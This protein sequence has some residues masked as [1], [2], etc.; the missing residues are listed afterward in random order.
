MPVR[1]QVDPTALAA[2]N[3]GI[4][5]VASA[6]QAANV[7]ANTGQL[8]GPS[9]AT[10]IHVNG[11][12]ADAAHWNKQI[13]AFRNGAPVRIQDVGRAI[14]CYQNIYAGAWFNGKRAIVLSI[15]RQPGSNTIQI[16]NEINQVMPRFIQTLPKSAH[17]TVFYDRSQ[18]IR[19]SVNDV[20]NTLA[21][22]RLCWWWR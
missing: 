14:D 9:Q 6:I 17:L 12:L 16:V 5:Q 20:Q 13:I 10:L 19:D 8:N 3:I 1:L 7:D 21:H 22:R 18:S 4:D 15:Q 2:R 11:Q